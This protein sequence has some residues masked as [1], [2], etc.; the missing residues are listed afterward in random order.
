M[1]DTCQPIDQY[2]APWETENNLALNRII[3]P[4]DMTLAR[5]SPNTSTSSI[6]LPGDKMALLGSVLSID[7]SHPS[8][9]LYHVSPQAQFSG[10]DS[11]W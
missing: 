8:N 5:P 9:D 11:G 2:F 10:T 3:S 7:F 6:Y 4:V 1:L